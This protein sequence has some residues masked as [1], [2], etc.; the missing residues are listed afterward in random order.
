MKLS[1]LSNDYLITFSLV[2]LSPPFLHVHHVCNKLSSMKPSP[3]SCLLPDYRSLRFCEALATS[4]NYL[5]TIH[6]FLCTYNTIRS[7]ICQSIF[8]IF[9]NSYLFIIHQLNC[10]N[11]L[12]YIVIYFTIYT[13]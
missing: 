3:L 8:Y 9:F 11:I 12:S 7:F 6:L 4:S 5:V 2:K 13:I 1:P 10:V